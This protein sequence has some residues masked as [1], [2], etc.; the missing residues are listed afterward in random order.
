MELSTNR[1]ATSCAATQERTNILWNPCTQ[2]PSIGPSPE[3]HQSTPHHPILSLQFPYT[4]LR[5]YLTSSTI[6]YG[7]PFLS[8]SCHLPCPSHFPLLHHYDYTWWRVQVRKLFIKQPSTLFCHFLSLRSK[9]SLRQLVLKH[10][11]NLI[12]FDPLRINPHWWSA[13][14]SL[15]RDLTL[16]EGYWIEFC[17]KLIVVISH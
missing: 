15:Y 6:P 12:I 9:Y 7:F 2:G 10:P 1:G 5:L 13:I 4:N 14:I 11:T 17:M 8:H 3:P 16:R